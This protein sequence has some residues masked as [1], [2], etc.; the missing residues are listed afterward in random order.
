VP[1]HYTLQFAEA[2]HLISS[3]ATLE[4]VRWAA[5]HATVPWFAIGGINLDNLGD[6]LWRAQ[7]AFAS[8][9]QFSTRR[10]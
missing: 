5:K 10:M 6:V 9:R 8:S 1:K 2:I 7:N 3:V 4:Y